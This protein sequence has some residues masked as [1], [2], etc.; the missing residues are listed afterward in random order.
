MNGN[1]SIM[2]ENSLAKRKIIVSIPDDKYETQK[3][4]NTKYLNYLLIIQP[5][6]HMREMAPQFN[7]QLNTLAASLS[8]IKPCAYD[9]ILDAY[10]A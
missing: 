9:T 8:N 7:F 6:L 1:G 4:K 5:P 2:N 10:K 3:R